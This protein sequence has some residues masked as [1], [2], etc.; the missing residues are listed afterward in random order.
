MC[1]PG[2]YSTTNMDYCQVASTGTYAATTQ[3]TTP[4]TVDTGYYADIGMTYQMRVFP[5]RQRKTTDGR[6]TILCKPG[7]YLNNYVCTA[8]PAGTFSPIGYS[9]SGRRTA[10]ITCPDGTW[11]V[12]GS[13]ECRF[14]PPGYDCTSTK[15]AIPSIRCSDGYY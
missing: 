15:A 14:C 10:G 6:H 3:V 9:S 1:G 5:N 2:F 8:S 11:S 13:I 12:E 4:A 7:Y